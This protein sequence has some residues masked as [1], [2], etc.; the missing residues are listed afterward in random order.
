MTA[1][2]IPVALNEGERYAGEIL[3]A[4]GSLSHR[5]VLLPGITHGSW[6]AAKTWAES[7]GGALPTRRELALLNANVR[8]AF[9]GV[10][11]WSAD[12]DQDGQA[13]GQHFLRGYQTAN[14]QSDEYHA[15]AVRRVV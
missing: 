2:S 14:R 5:L 4:D 11:H 3:N 13:W 6:Q 1:N 12:P 15:R 10:Y 8:D 7:V 9:D